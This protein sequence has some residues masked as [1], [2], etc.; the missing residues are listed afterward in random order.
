VA[1]YI[2]Y[3]L[4]NVMFARAVAFLSP[5]RNFM[6]CVKSRDPNSKQRRISDSNIERIT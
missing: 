4:R 2:T 1:N 6:S 3:H 5:L